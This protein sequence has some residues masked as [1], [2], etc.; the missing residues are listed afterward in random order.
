MRHKFDHQPQS[1]KSRAHFCINNF[2]RRPKRGGVE[3]LEGSAHSIERAQLRKCR[4]MLVDA[5]DEMVSPTR[6][7]MQRSQMKFL[8]NRFH[9]RH[10]RPLKL[11][12]L[13]A[14]K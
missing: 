13:S 9:C 10:N 5:P 1:S 3:T 12:N 2:S 6:E 8:H 11:E 7:E 4:R 14:A